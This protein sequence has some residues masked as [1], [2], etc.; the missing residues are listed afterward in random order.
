MDCL[1]EALKCGDT[2]L[3]VAVPD[4]DNA[5]IGRTVTILRHRHHSQMDMFCVEVEHPDRPEDL[6]LIRFCSLQNIR[7]R[8]PNC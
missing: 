8:A 2:A 5:F 7:G 3:I 6:V 4:S 1:G